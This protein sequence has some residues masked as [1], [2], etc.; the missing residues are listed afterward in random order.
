MYSVAQQMIVRKISYGIT[1][2]TLKN[3]LRPE[4]MLEF[5]LVIDMTILIWLEGRIDEI[6][7]MR[8]KTFN[9]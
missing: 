8:K 1:T 6:E 9:I 3:N 2:I 7:M 5:L 4:Q